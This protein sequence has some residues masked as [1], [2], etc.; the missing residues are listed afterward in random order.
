MNIK[1]DIFNEMTWPQF[2][3]LKEVQNLSRQ[4]KVRHYNLYLDQLN[5]ARFQNWYNSQSGG[6]IASVPTFEFTVNTANAGSTSSTQF[7]LPLVSSLPLNAVVDWGDGTTDAIT[8]WNQAQTTH[9]YSSSGIYTIKITGELSGWQFNNGGDR[10]KILNIASWSALNISVPNGFYGCANLTCTAT[11]A[12]IITT[13]SLANYFTDCINFNGAI[14][15]WDVSNVTDMSTMF[16]IPSYD[17]SI[18][19]QNIGNWNTSN[20][21]TM[22]HMFYNA[23]SFNNGGSSSIN[24]WN[25]GNV[26]NMGAVFRRA[27]AFNQP[28]GSWNTSKVT[29]MTSLFR[30]MT[31]NQPIGSWNVSNVISMSRMFQSSTAFNQPIGSW[32]TSKVTNMSNM[33]QEA[34]AFNQDI[35]TW[36]ISSVTNF[37][38]FMLGKTAAN[39]SAAN[40]DAIYNGWSSRSV[41]SGRTIL[42]GTIK[43]TAAGQAGRNILTGSPNL[44]SITDGG[45]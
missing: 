1:I 17:G 19:N 4:D 28:I 11:D 25:V 44:W 33:F 13:T 18:F 34:T 29:D 22:L 30:D 39:F 45:I 14:G 41:S 43:Y 6:V 21:T 37:S 38:S 31:F 8:T 36:N 16:W 2:E 42:F 5:I 24:N 10:F 35:G 12:P 27:T 26:T 20:V 9:T 15:N 7:K 40:L 3:Q 23:S 32:N